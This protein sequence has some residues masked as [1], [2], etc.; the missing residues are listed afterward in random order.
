MSARFG[1][2]LLNRRRE[3]G[4]SI[5]QVA[6]TIKIR[7]QI[8]EYFELGNFASMPPRGYAQGMISSYA[9]FLGLNPTEI[10][11]IYFD[12]LYAYE[13]GGE[14]RGGNFQGPAGPV[15]SRSSNDSG[16][17]LMVGGRPQS[18]RY[19]QR[20][21]QAGYVTENGSTTEIRAQRDRVRRTLPPAEGSVPMASGTA[22][23]P[24][25]GYGDGSR[26]NGSRGRSRSTRLASGARSA[27]GRRPAESG[28]RVRGD[29]ERANRTARPTAPDAR[30]ARSTRGNRPTSRDAY[31]SQGSRRGSAPQGRDGRRGA[32]PRGGSSRSV[33]STFDP[34]FLIGAAVIALAVLALLF[35]LVS[36]ACSSS[37]TTTTLAQETAKSESAAKKSSSKK[38]S[39]SK[40]KTSSSESDVSDASSDSDSADTAADDS[41]DTDSDASADSSDSGSA[42]SASSITVKVKIASKKTA[43]LEV[44][45]DGKLVFGKQATGP[46]NQEYTAN[47]SIDITT[48][49]PSYVTI[50]KNGKKVRYDSSTA[51]VARVS[52]TVPKTST[53]TSSDSS[54]DGSATDGTTSAQDSSTA[55]TTS[56]ALSSSTSSTSTVSASQ[57]S[58]YSQ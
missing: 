21:L 46:F 41:S 54:S 39:N 30:G 9:R 49:K 52:L 12:D 17:F 16:R 32:Q 37:S 20:A 25:A 31:R 1:E 18:T 56:A 58:S 8:I 42:E 40:K 38:N 22:R 36:R 57:T 50:T 55:S 2:L 7:P 47:E 29:G 6:N 51:G 53:G 4:L 23:N 14:R 10:V 48:S 28:G 5:Q 35:M 26:A 43:F 24:R 13:R 27:G 44:R 11:N 45:V 34:K 33:L 3:L 15:S 19:G